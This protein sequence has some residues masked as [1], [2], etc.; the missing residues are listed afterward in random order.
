M[1]RG[2]LTFGARLWEISENLHRADLSALERAEQIAEWVALTIPKQE[3]DD[4]PVQV[5]QVS[6]GDRKTDQVAQSAT[7]FANI[8]NYR[9]VITGLS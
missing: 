3:P 4:K 7:R 1:R 5:E 2:P 6:K 9:I 8:F